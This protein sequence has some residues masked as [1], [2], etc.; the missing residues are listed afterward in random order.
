MNNHKRKLATLVLTTAFAATMTTGAFA[1]DTLLISGQNPPVAT[2][3][4]E[5][6][7][8]ALSTME[9]T[10]TEINQDGEY[11]TITVKNEFQ[12]MVF[13]TSDAFLVDSAKG[14][15]FDLADMLDKTV[16]VYYGPQVTMSLP[17][18]SKATAIFTTG[19]GSV[20]N[21]ATVEAVQAN[22]D[23]SIIVTTDNGSRLVTINQDAEISP[24]LTKNIVKMDNIL[25]GSQV[26]LYYDIMTLSL[27]AQANTD[28][29][30]LLQQADTAAEDGQEA[31][32]VTPAEQVPA[33]TESM[34]PLRQIAEELGMTL[35]WDNEEKSV[36]L[37]K[38]A[39]SSKV[40]IGSAEASINKMRV[41]LDKEAKLINNTTYVPASLVEELRAALN[42]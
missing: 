40:I 36:T 4:A 24:W 9:G 27:P 16:R 2:A 22:D 7:A 20:A 10:I 38:D 23:G 37:S 11:P 34:V 13:Y 14:T 5:Q 12:E 39:F 42:Q 26:V 17:A 3:E 19:D 21:Y 28:K 18:Q 30:I 41:V 33:G 31:A 25:V 32:E 1:Q 35:K 8:L 15:A 6:Q 29:V